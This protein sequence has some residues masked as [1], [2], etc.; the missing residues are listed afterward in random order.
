[1]F[2]LELLFMVKRSGDGVKEELNGVTKVVN[3][4]FGTTI[5]L[6]EAVTVKLG[7]KPMEP[8]LCGYKDQ[9]KMLKKRKPQLNITLLI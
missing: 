8:T 6:L 7:N 2:N 1:M 9:I 4:Q 5:T 3:T